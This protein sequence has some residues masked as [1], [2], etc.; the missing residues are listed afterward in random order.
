M[1]QFRLPTTIRQG[2]GDRIRNTGAAKTRIADL[3]ALTVAPDCEGLRCRVAQSDGAYPFAG[4]DRNRAEKQSASAQR[5][6]D[7][8]R[9]GSRKPLHELESGALPTEKSSQD[10]KG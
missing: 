8:A 3:P 7:C 2:P 5:E 1:V 9:P 10:S 6:P 4:K